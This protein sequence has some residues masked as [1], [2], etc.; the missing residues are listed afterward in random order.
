[1]TLPPHSLTDRQTHKY[2]KSLKLIFQGNWSLA[3]FTY[4]TKPRRKNDI[5]SISHRLCLAWPSP[6][7]GSWK[8]RAVRS[9]MCYGQECHCCPTWWNYYLRLPAHNRLPESSSF[10][11]LCLCVWF[12]SERGAIVR[13]SG[14]CPTVS[15]WTEEWD[16]AIFMFCD[17]VTSINTP[18]SHWQADSHTNCG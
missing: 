2:N 5:D 11:T 1:M 17:T 9:K 7:S 18:A 12:L 16:L 14:R 4:V 10:S 13:G 6:C 8:A 3:I 15:P